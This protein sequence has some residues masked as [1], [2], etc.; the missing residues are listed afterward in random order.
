[1]TDCKAEGAG[2]IPDGI[3]NVFAL[4]HQLPK[5]HT[6]FFARTFYGS[7]EKVP[8]GG[9]YLEPLKIPVERWAEEPFKILLR[10]YFF[11]ECRLYKLLTTFVMLFELI[12]CAH[13]LRLSC[14]RF[15]KLSQSNEIFLKWNYCWYYIRSPMRV[16]VIEEYFKKIVFTYFIQCIQQT[17]HLSLSNR[18]TY[19][20]WGKYKRN[21]LETHTE[22]SLT[23][24]QK[25]V[26]YKCK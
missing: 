6:R 23:E 21:W 18:K 13:N 2:S 11:W 4:I 19:R 1:M 16:S 8:P 26:P 22:V 25:V 12:F 7:S 3:V 9:F 5:N 10:T 24:F 15:D 17:L 14:V 20:G